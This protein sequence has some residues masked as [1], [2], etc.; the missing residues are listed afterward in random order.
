MADI[1]NVMEISHHS[2]YELACFIE[3]YSSFGHSTKT[4]AG[5]PNMQA[6]FSSRTIVRPDLFGLPKTALMPNSFGTR[7]HKSLVVIAEV[8]NAR[9]YVVELVLY[10]AHDSI[11]LAVSLRV[12]DHAIAN[13]ASVSAHTDLAHHGLAGCLA[14]IAHGWQL[15]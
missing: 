15:A 4:V 3:P 9:P 6:L 10:L 2:V 13:R 5:L 8:V 11:G 7:G 14:L 12:S 1:D